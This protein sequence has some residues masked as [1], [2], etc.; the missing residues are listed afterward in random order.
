MDQLVY[1]GIAAWQYGITILLGSI[2][3]PI[4]VGFVAGMVVVTV[5]RLL[6]LAQVKTAIAPMFSYGSTYIKQYLGGP[7]CLDQEVEEHV[8]HAALVLRSE[9]WLFLY[10]VMFFLLITSFF[11][12]SSTT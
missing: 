3:N 9:L 1:A 11:A 4:L 6:L 8:R 10:A 5:S 12:L 7:V 2:T